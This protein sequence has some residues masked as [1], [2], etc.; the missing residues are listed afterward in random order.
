MSIDVMR[1]VLDRVFDNPTEKLVLLR[2]ADF[3]N[4]DGAGIYPMQDTVADDCLV[5]K[6]T[7]SAIFTKYRRFG[8]KLDDAGDM[9]EDT[10]M[11]QMI[12]PA[13]GH[14]Q[15]TYKLDLD[16]LATLP[17]TA[18]AKRRRARKRA[19]EGGDRVAAN[20]APRAPRVATHCAPR[21]AAGCAPI[22]TVRGSVSST[23][24][25][26]SVEGTR[27][28][29]AFALTPLEPAA[30]KRATRLSPAWQPNRDDVAFAIGAGLSEQ[31][32]QHEADQFRDHWLAASGAKACKR[33]W[34]AAW[35]TW[36]RNAVQ[37]GRARGPAGGRSGAG[38]R[39]PPSALRAFARAAGLDPDSMDRSR[40]G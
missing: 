29:D 16:I 31:E 23:E 37:W 25:H 39:E 30:Q 28:A 9:I 10:G 1:E 38:R 3:A 15:P 17:L 13:R 34:A 35:R 21:V 40:G 26:D 22:R 2:I 11:L 6:R 27:E 8:A 14:R 32:V 36:C 4:D 5:S 12:E 18:A 33:D 24:S 19:R 20:C 7:V